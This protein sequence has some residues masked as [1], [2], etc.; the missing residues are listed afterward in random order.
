MNKFS[1]TGRLVADPETSTFG[2]NKTK[3]TFRVAVRKRFVKDGEQ[4]SDFFT[5]TAFNATADFIA[6]YFHKGSPILIVTAEVHN[7]NYTKEDGTKVYGTQFIVNDVEFF[8]KKPDDA[9]DSDDTAAPAA[10][11]EATKSAA[12]PAP[13]K[14][15]SYDEYDDF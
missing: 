3:V 7:N 11:K 6:K 15:E 5:F 8:G 10:K 12:K 14:T 2:D 1:C 13:A 9:T 4:D